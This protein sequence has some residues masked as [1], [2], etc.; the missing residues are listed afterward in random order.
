MDPFLQSTIIVVIFMTGAYSIA[1]AK[2]NNGLADIA[3]GIGFILVAW[4]SFFKFSDREFLSGLTTGLVT[5]WGLRLSIHIFLRNHGK[6]EDS[7][8]QSMRQKWGSWQKLRSLTD[9][10]LFQGILLFLISTPVIW[11]N[12]K[13]GEMWWLA[14]LGLMIW[15]MGF[16]FESIGDYQLSQFIKTKESG[17]IMTKGLWQ[18]TRHPNYFGEV[19]MWW[20]I[21]LI[22][23]SSNFGWMTFLSPLLITFL[24][25]EVSGIP[26]LEKKYKGNGAFE[27]YKKRTN[28]FFPW[29][30]KKP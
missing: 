2:K 29:L 28:A 15:I 14:Y 7:R 13:G 10:F 27:A 17:Q 6:I 24:I 12:W 18:Y 25:L 22:A 16:F 19:S 4:F 1:L 11:V 5:L 21:F 30:P 26:M 8:Y 9:V 23:T 20:G 3:W